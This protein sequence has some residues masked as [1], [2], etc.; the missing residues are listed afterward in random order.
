[1]RGYQGVWGKWGCDVTG[2][3]LEL[4]RALW[5]DRS[6]ELVDRL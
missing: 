5:R 6:F 2:G 1:M 4:F 3:W